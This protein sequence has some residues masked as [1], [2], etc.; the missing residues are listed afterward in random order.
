MTKKMLK[1]NYKLNNKVLY[2]V[3]TKRMEIW[4]KK[5]MIFICK[6]KRKKKIRK[7]VKVNKKITM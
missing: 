3:L 2:Q 1:L 5:K 4:K 6:K 7:Y